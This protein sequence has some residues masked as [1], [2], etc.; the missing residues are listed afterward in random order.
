M[1][2]SIAKFPCL[3]RNC[4][5]KIAAYEVIASDEASVLNACIKKNGKVIDIAGFAKATDAAGILELH[6]TEGVQGFFGIKSDY[7]II[8]LDTK[9]W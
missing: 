5:A 7:N 9:Y 4:R 1:S 3:R 2:C 8:F 6:F